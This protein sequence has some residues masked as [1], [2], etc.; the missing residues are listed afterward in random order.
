MATDLISAFMVPVAILLLSSLTADIL[1]TSIRFDTAPAVLRFTVHVVVADVH[2]TALYRSVVLL[3][4]SYVGG[5]SF[6]LPM[7]SIGQ[8]PIGVDTMF[9]CILRLYLPALLSL[10]L[11]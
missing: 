8:I 10:N 3:M 6:C 7:K 11:L 2:V 1:R 9:G 4:F 5:W